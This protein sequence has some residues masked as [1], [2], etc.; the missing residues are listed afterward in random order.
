VA[1]VG[2]PSSL[3]VPA[4]RLLLYESMKI[5]GVSTTENVEA[6]PRVLILGGSGFIGTR[7]AALLARQHISFCIGDL[8]KSLDF[9]H[10]SAKCD[11]RQRDSFSDL[12]A[13]SD[14]IVNL[15][16]AHRDD[17]RPLSLYREINVEGASAVCSVARETGVQ[18]I[19]FTS[20]VAVYGF[21]PA[22]VDEK[23]PFIPFNEYGKTKLEAEGI[24]RAWAREDS[25]RTLVIVR[26]T[27]VFGEGN[28]GNVYTLLNQIAARR[29]PIVGDGKNI[30][31]MA[32]VDNVAAFLLHT[33]SFEPGTHIF[34]YADKPDMDTKTLVGFARRSLGL[35]E[36]TFRLPK[37]AA[38][39]GGYLIDAVAR[40]SGRTFPVSA[41][42][43]R[44]FC[45]STQFLADRVSQSGFV[46]PFT[47]R[48]GLERTIRFEFPS[49][50][51][52]SHAEATSSH[53]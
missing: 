26:P 10:R 52:D 7:L 32:Y 48:Q 15:A 50:A 18:K 40:I 12:A 45:E 16:A 4:K 49:M 14:V 36:S 30:K 47:L 51:R 20:S 46:P 33:L 9:P 28:R 23:G 3:E 39:A 34:N 44:K 43:V 2:A 19:V 6:A 41:I 38:L 13:G 5:T 11:V 21:H 17:V 35:N 29:F 8:E 42:R 22:P 37:V 27:V 24:Y 1:S 25:K 53:I 31:S